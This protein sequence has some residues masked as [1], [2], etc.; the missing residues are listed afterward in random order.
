MTHAR[1]LSLASFTVPVWEREHE[2]GRQGVPTQ[3]TREWIRTESCLKAGCLCER[4]FSDVY[5]QPSILICQEDRTTH[6]SEGRWFSCVKTPVDQ[7]S[8][9]RVNTRELEP[10]WDHSKPCSGVVSGRKRAR[11]V[12]WTCFYLGERAGSAWAWPRKAAHSAAFLLLRIVSECCGKN[13]YAGGL[14]SVGS[15]KPSCSAP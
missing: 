3:E 10:V 15:F 8:E 5:T 9:G 12:L 4:S 1:S 11:R 14:A 2:K 6:I 7:S 13:E